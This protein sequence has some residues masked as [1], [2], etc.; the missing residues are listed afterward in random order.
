MTLA[1]VIVAVLISAIRLYP[2]FNLI[3]QNKVEQHLNQSLNAQVDIGTLQVSRQQPF[4]E[5]VAERVSITP[6][7]PEAQ[8][9]GLDRIEIQL[10]LLASIFAQ[11]LKLKRITL[12]G[13]DISLHRDQTGQIHVNQEFPLWQ[14]KNSDNAQLFDSY[15]SLYQSKIRWS[16][17]I[18]GVD[19]QFLDV[20]ALLAPGLLEME[21]SLS[22][23]L[24]Q[25]LGNTINLQAR[26]NGSLS[27]LHE[28][29]IKFYADL[30]DIRIDEISQH[31]PVNYEL[32]T[33]AIIAMRAWGEYNQGQLKAMQG[34]VN[35]EHLQNR[36]ANVDQALCL[37]D[38]VLEALSLDYQ[39]TA[40][41]NQWL[42]LADNINTRFNG[43]SSPAD[44]T[45]Q[46][47]LKINL[48]S[49]Q[50]QVIS[51]YLNT[52][53]LGALCNSVHA[54]MPGL[55]QQHLAGLRA[56]A[57]LDDLLVHIEHSQDQS[58]SFQYA[59][60]FQ[61]A[62]LWH[63]AADRKIAGLSGRLTGG[64]SGGKVSLTSQQVEL[65]LPQMYPDEVL[66]IAL[67]GDLDWQHYA[68]KH[69]IHTEHLRLENN[70]LAID[71]RFTALLDKNEIYSDAQLYIARASAAELDRY[72]PAL[73]QITRTKKWFGDALHDGRIVASKIILRGLLRDFP[74]HK[75]SGV[76]L[77]DVSLQDAVIEYK[78]DWP[79][80]S[81]VQA[82]I[83]LNKDH[84]LVVPTH[85]IM[86]DSVLTRARL[87]I[88]SFLRAVLEAEGELVGEG[89]N[90]I[91]FLADSGLVARRNSVADQ[92]SLQGDTKLQLSF[93]KS[94]SQKVALPFRV[95]GM[96]NFIGNSLHVRAANMSMQDLRGTLAFDEDGAYGEYLSARLYGH[97][98][99]LSAKALGAG[100]SELYFNG[101]FDLD[102]YI[103]SQLPQFKPFVYGQT[104]IQGSL[105]LPS[106]FKQNNPEKLTLKIT[107]QLQGIESNLPYP[108]HKTSPEPLATELLFDQKQ[109]IMRWQF[110]DQ[111][112]LLFTM[113]QNQPFNL[114]LI[115]F[116]QPETTPHELTEGL[117]LVGYIDR[118]P[119]ASWLQTY[120]QYNSELTRLGI[121]NA[122]STLPRVD[123][124]IQ[125]LDWLP[126]P[127]QNMS[128]QAAMEDNNYVLAMS[129]SLGAGR[130]LWPQLT[131]APVVFDMEEFKVHHSEKKSEQVIDPNTLPPFIF[132]AK[133][134]HLK[135]KLIREVDVTAQSIHDGLFFSD[136][137]FALEDLQARGQGS[138][139]QTDEDDIW[140]EFSFDLTTS[141]LADALESLN[142]Q[143][144]LRNGNGSIRTQLS[145][146]DAPHKVALAN[147]TGRT[148]LDIRK[149][150]ITEVEPGAGRLLALFNLSA[151][152]RRLSLDFKDVTAKGFAFNTISGDLDL[153]SGGEMKMEQVVIDSSAAVIEFTGTTNIVDQT[154]DQNIFVTPSVTESLPAAGAI[155]GG[156]IGAAA[157]F[158]VDKVAKVV[159]LDKALKY[160]YSMTG[161]WEQPEIVKIKKVSDESSAE[162]TLNQ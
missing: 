66:Q 74:F 89:Q 96:L 121:N 142:Y 76:M 104:P 15:I 124:R 137:N 40:H 98:L 125:A 110:A 161:T 72:L 7:H 118:L 45:Q 73:T 42:L 41:D 119:I 106:M 20:S 34:S 136:I 141:D 84:V 90:L 36:N 8:A 159:G 154:Y 122:S 37:S 130:V 140:S 44:Q 126:W 83:R 99:A 97:K 103:S 26:I 128:L 4:S 105:Y 21:L 17:A 127:A 120:Q 109:A 52:L 22:A 75:R 111:A 38:R 31:L 112:S 28:A 69:S 32:Q 147:M 10:D 3:V 157:G 43:P 78:K 62:T 150:S 33:Q 100:A 88:P 49:P 6:A 12:V 2:D 51:L 92:L 55:V 67:T 1:L 93:S 152:T 13:L 64:D 27:A 60:K 82:T 18:T 68:N 145:W 53:N 101:K 107:S 47:S 87:E 153:Q 11:Q 77:A 138:W 108:M 25:R 48:Q 71:T 58:P 156:P 56:H 19:Y 131:A 85:G 139:R 160:Q 162:N 65:S 91:Q 59:S 94:L 23:R 80:F 117:K 95:S 61:D 113:S 81:D 57:V 86:Y 50:T 149:G 132:K 115:E 135:D 14:D 70:D 9:W 158:V 39:L 5:L 16:D 133:R 151:L 79:A 24:P 54:Y 46:L 35:L 146:P 29:K 123:L 114:R 116:G 30:Q 144:G 102:A 155:V 129:S 143:T 148:S 63:V 134:F